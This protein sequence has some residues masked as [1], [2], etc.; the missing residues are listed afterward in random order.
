MKSSTTYTSTLPKDLLIMLTRYSELFEIPK[1][2]IIEKALHRY[3]DELKK[4]EYVKSFKKANADADML[5]M[6]EEGLDDYLNVLD[7]K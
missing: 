5:T 3:F 4:A 1:N 7:R 2:R 6:A